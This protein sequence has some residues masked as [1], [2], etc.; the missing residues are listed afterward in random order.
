MTSLQNFSTT[1]IL[2]FFRIRSE[3][4]GGREGGVLTWY[5]FSAAST[6]YQVHDATSYSYYFSSLCNPFLILYPPHQEDP[7]IYSR[8]GACAHLQSCS[9]VV[10]P[11]LCP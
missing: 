11:Q 9:M 10:G 7:Q 3:G 1:N 5:A 4:E 6:I 2:L 8:F